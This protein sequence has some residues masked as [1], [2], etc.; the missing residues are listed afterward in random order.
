MKKED[1]LKEET[2]KAWHDLGEA[3]LETLE[4]LRDNEPFE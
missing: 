1:N 2:R 4:E 3:W